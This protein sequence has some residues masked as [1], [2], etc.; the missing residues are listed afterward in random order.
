MQAQH[1]ELN[2]LVDEIADTLRKLLPVCEPRTDPDHGDPLYAEH[3]LV[4]ARKAQAHLGQ[5]QLFVDGVNHQIL[6][7]STPLRLLTRYLQALYTA[8]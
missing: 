3:Q 1:P 2:P 6:V 8:E 7:G 5:P 4:D